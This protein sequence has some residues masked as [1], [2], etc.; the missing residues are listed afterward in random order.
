MKLAALARR[1]WLLRARRGLYLV[2]PLEAEPGRP[3]VVE[4]PWVLAQAVFSPCYIGGWSA[5]EHWGLT[6][7]IFRS[8]LVVT[9]AN[10][11]SRSVRLLGHEFHL[12]WVP[13]ERTGGATLVWRG[14]EHVPVS[15][16]ER[17]IVDCLRHPALCG[18][19]RHL[20]QIMREYGQSREHDFAKLARV[21]EEFGT[22]A[23]WKRLGCIAEV[24]WP[25]ET[26]LVEEARNRLTAG[27]V[28][29]DPEV[30]KTGTL[31]RRWRL[32]VNVSI[33]KDTAA[34]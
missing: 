22:G 8:T 28:K 7:Q 31:S 5:A 9:A 3:M 23:A 21:A 29:L 20:A 34:A 17:T 25:E 19:V 2:L 13:Q 18:G 16:P 24:V 14:S 12:F 1:G 27:Y 11:R 32:W 10:I 6:E 4:D 15:G 26:A 30:K 33:G